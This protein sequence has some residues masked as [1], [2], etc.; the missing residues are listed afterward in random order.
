MEAPPLPSP[1]LKPV[2]GDRGLFPELQA[3]AFLNHAAISPPSTVVAEAVQQ[4]ISDYAR[5][6]VGALPRWMAQRERLRASLAELI[7]ASP[8]DLA[9]TAGTTRGITDIAM[10]IA[11]KPGDRIVLFEGEFPANTTPWQLAARTFGLEVVWLSLEGVDDGS[12]LGRLEQTLRQGVRLV[13]VSAVQFSTGLR[14]PLGQMT[15][16]CHAHGAELAVDAI[17]A[18]GVMPITVRGV[19]YLACG[20]HK[21]LM[22]MEGAGFLYI[23]PARVSALNPRTVGWLSHEDPVRFL[24]EG[25]GFLRYDRPLRR[26]ADVFEGSAQNLLGLAA[27]EASLSLITAIGVHRVFAH[28]CTYLDALEKGLV[29][30]GFRSLRVSGAESGILSVLPPG[31]VLEWH[32]QLG[33]RGV[34]CSTPDGKL[35]FAPHWPNALAEVPLVLAAVDEILA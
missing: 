33:Q 35:R 19:D 9:L 24:I 34:A 25:A 4:A 18:V 7:G 30:R 12:F 22:G 11:W 13:A 2:L 21:W 3:R 31:E 20:A 5:H 8:N 16:L 15:A 17:Q 10:G 14:M 27:L 28:V 1:A 26:K 23:N 32:R 6:G 29:E